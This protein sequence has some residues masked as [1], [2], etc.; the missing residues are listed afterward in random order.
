MCGSSITNPDQGVRAQMDAEQG[1]LVL[2]LLFLHGNMN[3]QL[4]MCIYHVSLSCR[5]MIAQNGGIKY[6]REFRL[7]FVPE[8][9]DTCKEVAH[10]GNESIY[11]GKYSSY[12][13][14]EFYGHL[15]RPDSHKKLEKVLEKSKMHSI[16]SFLLWLMKIGPDPATLATV[17]CAYR[18]LI[19]RRELHAMSKSMADWNAFYKEFR[20][21][22]RNEIHP[23]W[24]QL[25][26][27]RNALS[28]VPLLE[29]GIWYEQKRPVHWSHARAAS[30]ASIENNSS[31]KRVKQT[32]I[33]CQ[34]QEIAAVSEKRKL[35]LF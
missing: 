28:V 20:Q 17:Q 24:M 1:F 7:S 13:Y 23:K 3:H 19:K 22:M 32:P 12:L 4:Q 6:P 30:A 11:G 33:I 35:I 5:F 29:A 27:N 34:T 25:F 2:T 21:R 26:Y 15:T 14:Y 31:S 10:D 18:Y 9:C 8:R 16:G